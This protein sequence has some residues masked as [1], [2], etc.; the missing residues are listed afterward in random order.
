M[1]NLMGKSGARDV[2]SYIQSGV[3]EELLKA[4]PDLKA[5]NAFDE[6]LLHAAELTGRKFIMIIDEWDAPIR[7]TPEIQK[8][9]LQFLRTLFKGSGTTDKI[10]AAAYMTGIL[11]IKKDGSQS[12]ISDFKKFSMIKPRRF[13]G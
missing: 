5:G 7:K 6:T 2:V 12:A 3:T 1:T 8:M 11:P 4:Y 9:Y 13:G 10:F